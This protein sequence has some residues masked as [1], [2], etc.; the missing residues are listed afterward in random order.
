[1]E[2][3]KIIEAET[4][5]QGEL[6]PCKYGYELDCSYESFKK[7]LVM[8]EQYLNALSKCLACA[9]KPVFS[10]HVPGIAPAVL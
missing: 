7:G 5:N 2:K 10:S 9:K 3:F 6:T 8:R 4:Q 1:M